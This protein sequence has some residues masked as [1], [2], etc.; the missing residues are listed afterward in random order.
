[1]RV[2]SSASGKL[3]G[4]EEAPIFPWYLGNE[5]VYTMSA[6]YEFMYLGAEQGESL[7]FMCG[8]SLERLRGVT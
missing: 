8:I 5:P 2:N 7:C 4:Q 3:E 6:L 1:M